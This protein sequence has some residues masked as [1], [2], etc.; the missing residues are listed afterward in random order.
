MYTP[1]VPAKGLHPFE[2]LS[3]VITYKVFPFGVYSLVSVQRACGYKGFSTYI[4]SVRSLPCVCPDVRGQVGAVAET[5]FTHRTTIR[6]VFVFLAVVLVG[7]ERQHGILE[8]IFQT[9]GGRDKIFDVRIQPV[10]LLL[11]GAHPELSMRCLLLLLLDQQRRLRLLLL[12]TAALIRLAVRRL[13]G[14]HCRDRGD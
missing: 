10:Q 4:T 6:P 1:H 5:F 3:T 12:H 8:I 7:V 2:R 9:G 14:L 13:G 11:V